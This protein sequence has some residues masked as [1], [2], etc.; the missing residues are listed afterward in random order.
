MVADFYASAA[1]GVR[2]I[3][4]FSDTDAYG[5]ILRDKNMNGF[6][7]QPHGYTGQ[8]RKPDYEG[9]HFGARLYLPDLGRFL[10]ID[11]AD[12]FCN[13]YSYVGNNPLLLI[14]LDGK[15]VNIAPDGSYELSMHGI[16][17][18]IPNDEA[19]RSFWS[20]QKNRLLLAK[21]K[22]D[23]PQGV[24]ITQELQV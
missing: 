23:F 15:G 13:S 18:S 6:E 3:T 1:T 21:G 9:M 24:Q 16:K 7:G 5:N 2:L 20:N 11:P 12:Q 10:Q 8:E 14:D 4:A 22:I 19:S 17:A